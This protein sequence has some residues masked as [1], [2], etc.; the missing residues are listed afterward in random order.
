MMNGPPLPYWAR[1]R[2]WTVFSRYLKSTSWPQGCEIPSQTQSCGQ[3]LLNCA[4]KH[5]VLYNK[6][7]QE[8]GAASGLSQNLLYFFR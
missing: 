7:S 1:I 2:H 6:P 4:A 8:A 3:G 5:M